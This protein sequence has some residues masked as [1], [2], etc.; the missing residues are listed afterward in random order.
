MDR[1][2]GLGRRMPKTMVLWLIGAG[3]ISGLPLF[4]GFVSKWLIYNAALEAGQFIP[5]LIAWIVSILT[6]FY[7]LKAT[8]GVFLGNETTEL[9]NDVHEVPWPMVFGMAILAGGNILLGIAPQLAVGYLINPL[10]S[11]VGSRPV[12]GVSW[13]GLTAGSGDWFTTPGLILA[14]LAVGVG[15]LVYWIAIPARSREL[16]VKVSPSGMTDVFSGGEALAGS[17]HLSTSDFSFILKNH[18]GSFYRRADMD[19]YYLVLWRQLLRIS[20]IL[21]RISRW[22]E[23]RA[24]TVMLILVML[25][26]A[27]IELLPKT[28]GSQSPHAIQL[29]GW[30][31]ILGISLSL[32]AL[33]CT[34]YA[35]Q[36]GRRLLPLFALSGLLVLLGQI[37]HQHLMSLLLLEGSSLVALIMVWKSGK[38]RAVRFV[39]LLAVLVSAGAIIS[40]TLMLDS[41][42]PNLLLWL[43]ITG[44]AVKLALVPL[45]LWLP[46]VA[47]DTPAPIVGLVVSVVDVAAFGELLM[48]RQSSPWLFT[49][50]GPWLA[51]GLFSALGGALLMLAQDDLKRLLAFSTIEDMGYLTLGV[52]LGGDLGLRGAVL[53]ITVHSLG[54][55]LLFS[56]LAFVESENGPPTLAMRGLTARYPISGFGFL[57]GALV[58]MGV[59]PTAGYIA[60]WRLYGAALQMGF[61]YLLIMLLSTALALLAYSRVVALCWWGAG[62]DGDKSH[63]PTLLRVPIIG[64][65]VLLLLMGLWPGLLR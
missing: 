2:G 29:I 33:L 51:I 3:S 32:S 58:M 9:T 35:L 52:T 27:L 18:L 61:P 37:T 11:A 17:S 41:A 62:D 21:G 43:M 49:L 54:K 63:E 8:T 28:G 13:L 45:Y 60:R 16:T 59:P 36:K 42:S 65:C 10:L 22:L 50:T 46:M 20:D 55:A 15:V 7:F 56:S 30:P 44:F 25:F 48:L 19:R 4:S 64:L 39:Y 6:V 31:V 38:T 26:G 24:V 57:L 1:L 53:G 23:K 14:I 5:A 12:I 40:G 47:E 34:G